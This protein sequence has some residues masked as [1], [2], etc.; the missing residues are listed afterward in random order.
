MQAWECLSSLHQAG[1]TAEL[2]LWTT[3][4]GSFALRDGDLSLALLF[5]H[6]CPISCLCVCVPVCLEGCGFI[7]RGIGFPL[8]FSELDIALWWWFEMQ[9]GGRELSLPISFSFPF[10]LLSSHF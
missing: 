1:A 10:F 3:S 7:V 5:A 8:A 9:F 2:A 6:R 4:A